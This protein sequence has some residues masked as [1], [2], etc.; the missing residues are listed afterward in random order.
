MSYVGLRADEDREG[1]VSSKPNITARF[2]FQ[3]DG[4][5]RDD[6]ISMLEEAGLGLPA[7]YEWRSRSGCYFCFYQRKIEWLGLREHHPALFEKAMAYEKRDP[8]TGK[9]FTW[10]QGE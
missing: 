9:V 7:Y 6:V 10:Q 4:V 8:A 3:E 1:Y 2:P 5:V